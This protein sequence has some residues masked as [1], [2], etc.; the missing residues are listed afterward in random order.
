MSHKIRLVSQTTGLAAL[1]LMA[2]LALAAIDS[3][4]DTAFTQAR[5]PSAPDVPAPLV[6]NYQGRLTDLA[7]T[8]KPDGTYQMVFA[9]YDV[10]SGGAP[11]WSETRDVNVKGGL[12]SIRLGEV[13]PFPSPT[14]YDGRALW[15][16]ITVG[17]DPQATPRLPVSF[18]AYTL[19][20]NRAASAGAATTADLA[21]NADRLGG[22]PPASYA[23]ASHTHDAGAI[24]AGTLSTDRYSA[25]ADLAA[26]ARIGE[27]AGQVAYGNHVHDTRYYTE[28]ESDAR[29]VN[30]AGDTMSGALTVPRI[31]YTAPRTHTSWLAARALCPAATWTTS[32]PTACGGA[33]IVSGNGALVAPVHLPQGAVVTQFRV[34]F[35]DVSVSD[36]TVIP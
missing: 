17:A 27:A 36:M 28:G 5:E 23:A 7:G 18:V 16:G 26:E 3:S 15:L 12:F 25:Y 11:L 9:L 10:A 34:F 31:V 29:F 24:T 8:A 32:T 1:I 14:I 33:Y 13:A 20:A 19:Y 6:L 35:Y 22:Q 21:A 30:K 4:A 2:M